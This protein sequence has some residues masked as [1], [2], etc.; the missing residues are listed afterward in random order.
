MWQE[1]KSELAEIETRAKAAYQLQ[2]KQ[3]FG[4]DLIGQ[5]ETGKS[6]ENGIADVN[7]GEIIEAAI[8]TYSEPFLKVDKVKIK[9]QKK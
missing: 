9:T 5:F 1:K 7:T 3:G 2:T 4:E 6:Q 8:A